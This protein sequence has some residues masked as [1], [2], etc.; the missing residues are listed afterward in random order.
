MLIISP[1]YDA[2]QNV[3]CM[4]LLNCPIHLALLE[5]KYT[6]SNFE[7]HFDRDFRTRPM[8]FLPISYADTYQLRL[9]YFRSPISRLFTCDL[10]VSCLLFCLTY[11][12]ITSGRSSFSSFIITLLR[13][14]FFTFWWENL[15]L[16]SYGDV[17]FP[18]L[19]KLSSSFKLLD[20]AVLYRWP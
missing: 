2:Y 15:N 3:C 17:F 10:S 13:N 20:R 19:I 16:W 14:N 18:F 1:L 7:L 8:V 5:S 4:F 9:L 12:D 11:S 6:T